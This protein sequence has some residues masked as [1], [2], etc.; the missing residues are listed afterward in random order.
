MK[1]L[2]ARRGL[3]APEL[4]APSG[5]SPLRWPQSHC[6]LGGTQLSKRL[7]LRPQQ[8]QPLPLLPRWC[9]HL[10]IALAAW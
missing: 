6:L 9:C 2:R 7:N 4:L 3:A 5:I 1:R 10:L 8:W